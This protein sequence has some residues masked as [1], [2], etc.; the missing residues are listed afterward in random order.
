MKYALLFG[1]GLLAATVAP[2]NSLWN[3][4]VDLFD[5][6]GDLIPGRMEISFDQYN[7]RGRLVTS[8]RSTIAIW[9]DDTGE[10]QTRII[11]AERD[12]EDVTEERREDPSSGAPPFGGRPGDDEEADDN[13]FAGLSRSPFDPDEQ[14]H[15]TITRIGAVENVDGV[16]SQ[17]FEFRHRTS[18]SAANVGTAWL[19]AETGEPVLLRLTIEPLPRVISEFEMEQSFARD[20]QGQ[21]V[22][23]RL[24]F[25]GAGSILFLQRRIESR[26]IFSE[27]FRAQ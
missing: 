6:Y 10:T 8:D 15:V 16:R 26:L 25:V 24:D 14:E 23:R 11:S 22:V 13:A 9:V 12:G 17:V 18:D 20:E 4:A 27:Y 7:G 1:F 19:D 2:A 21:W 3:D 5:A